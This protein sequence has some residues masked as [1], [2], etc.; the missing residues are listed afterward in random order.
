[1]RSVVLVRSEECGLAS[2][3]LVKKNNGGELGK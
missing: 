2:S 3:E 1:M